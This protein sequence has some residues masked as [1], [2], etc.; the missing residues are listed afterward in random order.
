M[1]DLNYPLRVSKNK[2]LPF[3]EKIMMEQKIDEEN[4]ETNLVFC[5]HPRRPFSIKWIPRSVFRNPSYNNK[6][7]LF[8]NSV[9][10]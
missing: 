9:K 6:I 8:S 1:N 4:I 2:P 10:F 3:F 7:R 5:I